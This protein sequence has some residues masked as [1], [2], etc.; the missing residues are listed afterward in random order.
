MNI[1]N[2]T[3][4]VKHG[5]LLCCAALWLTACGVQEPM[6]MPNPPPTPAALQ[7]GAEADEV[8]VS[9]TVSAMSADTRSWV[10]VGD[11]QTVI[12]HLPSTGVLSIDGRAA[13]AGD[14]IVGMEITTHGHQ[15]GDLVIVQDAKATTPASLL[16]PAASTAGDAT[17]TDSA[18]PA[19]PAAPAVRDATKPDAAP[20]ATTP[21]AAPAAPVTPPIKPAAP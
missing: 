18:A 9:G 4:S 15:A 13:L 16:P 19:P 11:G 21:D 12:G 17:A 1:Q 5:A 8:T 20:A 2:Q 10:Q 6:M 7:Q 3:P 14:L